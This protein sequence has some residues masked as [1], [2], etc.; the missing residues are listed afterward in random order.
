MGH[1]WLK[2]IHYISANLFA[3]SFARSII[4]FNVVAEPRFMMFSSIPVYDGKEGEWR[5]WHEAVESEFDMLA[6][7]ARTE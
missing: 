7:T 1:F 6:V 2:C 5:R 4:I 3:S